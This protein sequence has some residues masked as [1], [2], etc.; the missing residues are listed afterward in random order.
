MAEL[1]GFMSDGGMLKLIAVGGV[2]FLLILIVIIVIVVVIK[3][4]SSG[5]SGPG[6]LPGGLTVNVGGPQASTN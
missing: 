2:M 3:S 1:A 5:S 6:G 4:G